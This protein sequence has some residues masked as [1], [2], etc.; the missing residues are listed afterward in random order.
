MQRALIQIAFATAI[1]AASTAHA[2][3][4]KLA[5]DG[6]LQAAGGTRTVS[7]RLLCEPD[8]DGGAISVELWVPQAYKLKDFD[9]DDFEGPDAAAGNRAL[10]RVRVAGASGS[11]EIT[12]P[13]AGWYAGEDP[14]TF[15][16]GLSQR[17][18]RKGKIATLLAA[19]DPKHTQLVWVQTGFDDPKRELRAT[20]AL[21]AA[22][23][24]QIRDTV[25]ECL[26]P[27]AKSKPAAKR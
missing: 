27:A 15:V 22:T 13:A 14:D 8:P 10:S 11:T 24:R 20:F 3:L 12:Y 18:H 26:A 6:Q 19:V 9:Y 25:G 5:L 21:D 1:A 23:V 4:H 7:L 16:F 2:E 17:S